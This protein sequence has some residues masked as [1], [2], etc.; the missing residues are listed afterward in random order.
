MKHIHFKDAPQSGP[1]AHRGPGVHFHHLL[2]GDE[3]APDNFA[4]MVV[5]IPGGYSAP[6]HRH[7]F[8]QVRIMLDGSF[9][10]GPDGVQE[11]GSIGYFTEGTY[12]T[13]EGKGK[14]ATLLLQCGGA[15]GA[16]YMSHRQ[17]VAANAQLMERGQFANGV[18]T[19]RDEHGQAHNKDGYE[20]A[21]EQCFQRDL[22]YPKPRYDAP[23]LL[24][25]ERF[26]Y[27]QDERLNA[28]IK[29]FGV[30]NERGTSI[31]QIRVQAGRHARVE[32]LRQRTLLYVICG[33]G[34]VVGGAVFL[35]QDAFEIAPG[36]ALEIVAATDAELFRFAL[37]QFS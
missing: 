8:E 20:A 29:S 24:R 35:S 30:F 18:Y 23:V 15:S 9:N 25:P 37:P 4:L 2:V 3:G 5:D 32:A 21:W 33:E 14:S 6:R 31:A 13:Q 26:D 34:Q 11:A 1:E 36:E 27:V 19:W 16:G 7:N 12:Y 10:F 17:L 22:H 28:E